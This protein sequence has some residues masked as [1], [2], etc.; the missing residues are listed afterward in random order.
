MKTLLYYLI[1][2]LFICVSCSSDDDT[3]FIPE[4]DTAPQASGIGYIQTDMGTNSLYDALKTEINAN[5][6]LDVIAEIDHSLNA[7]TAGMTLNNTRTIYFSNPSI[8]AMLMENNMKLGLDLPLRI[9]VYE[10]GNKSTAIF[11]SSAYLDNRYALNDPS[12]LQLL[13][14]TQSSVVSI[15]GETNVRYNNAIADPVDG[16]TLVLS[17]NDF[18]TTYDNI[19]QNINEL[20]GVTIFAEIDLKAN[21][22]ETGIEL[23][24]AKLIIFGNPNLGTPLMQDKPSISVDLPQ[25]MLVYQNSLGA[26][27]VA[28]NNPYYLSD[29][30]NLG[31]LNNNNLATIADAL[32][33][34]ADAG[35]RVD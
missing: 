21:A 12:N 15:A 34:I 24:P 27:N 8:T 20:T 18:D 3:V 30:H 25:K 35:V 1:P 5:T 26:V 14:D 4:S 6:N 7:S 33:N 29:R 17:E 32:S 11:N 31:T 10:N 2:F 9:S 23:P 28:Y 22:F 13:E 19:V 16:I